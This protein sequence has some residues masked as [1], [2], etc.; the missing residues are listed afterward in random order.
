MEDIRASVTFISCRSF[1][2]V[3]VQAVGIGIGSIPTLTRPE[4][5][6]MIAK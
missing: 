3:F 5:S 2:Q 4:M 1:G 6:W